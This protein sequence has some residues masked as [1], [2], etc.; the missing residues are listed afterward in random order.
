MIEIDVIGVMY[1]DPIDPTDPE[2]ALVAYPGWR[3]NIT[4]GGLELRPDLE[5][6]VVTPARLRRVWSGDDPIAP[7]VTVVLKFES[8]AKALVA[9]APR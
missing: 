8:E 7:S 3:V 5:P 4:A 1:R 9:L 2:E 6:F